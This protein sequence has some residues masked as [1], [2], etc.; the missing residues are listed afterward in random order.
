MATIML[1]GS[2]A[3]CSQFHID[4]T[5]S[6]EVQSQFLLRFLDILLS[7]DSDWLKIIPREK[8]N[9]SFAL[10]DT[11]AR[12]DLSLRHKNVKRHA[13]FYKFASSNFC[14]KTFS[15]LIFTIEINLT[16]KRILI[17]NF[18]ISDRP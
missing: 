10:T 9:S 18:I 4:I 5:Q 2:N 1:D 16:A 11:T 13:L 15:K 17:M 7:I 14:Y 8:A 12:L 3:H 6:H